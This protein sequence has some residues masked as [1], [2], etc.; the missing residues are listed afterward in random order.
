MF[1]AVLTHH[2]QGQEPPASATPDLTAFT[3]SAGNPVLPKPAGQEN[4]LAVPWLNLGLLLLVALLVSCISPRERLTQQ[5][6][7]LTDEWKTNIAYQANLPER[8]LDWPTA[9]A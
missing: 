9:L 4:Q 6:G 3:W 1:F 8:I 7:H 2:P 5:M